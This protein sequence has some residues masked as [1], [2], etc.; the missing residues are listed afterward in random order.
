MPLPQWSSGSFTVRYTAFA[1]SR[2][3][4][5]RW[6]LP[7]STL[8][9]ITINEKKKEKYHIFIVFPIMLLSQC[10]Y[11]NRKNNWHAFSYC[12]CLFSSHNSLSAST[13]RR[14][15]IFAFDKLKRLAAILY[16]IP[17]LVSSFGWFS[18]LA[19]LLWPHTPSSPGI[20]CTSTVRITALHR[21][22]AK[23]QVL[24]LSISKWAKIS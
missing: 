14:T 22:Q 17:F 11:I 8:K 6:S 21:T 7:G 3:D 19:L 18:L 16:Y 10:T 24:V 13:N 2:P 20:C 1:P 4:P 12:A 5:D 15:N 9:S 23:I